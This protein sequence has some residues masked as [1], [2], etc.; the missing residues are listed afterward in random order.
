M[1][2]AAEPIA[3]GVWLI[4]GGVPRRM[5]VYAIRD[6]NGVLLFDAGIAQM[7][8]QILDATRTLGGITRVVLGHS[9]PDHRGAAPGLGAPVF[10]HP[11]E[12]GDAQGDGGRHYM[13]PNKLAP[14]ARWAYRYLLPYWDGGPV[15]VA[16]TIDEGEEVAGFEVVHLPGHAPGQIALW[17]VRDRL[18]LVS[19]CF[20]TLDVRTGLKSAPRA[21]HTAFT[22][23]VEVARESIRKIARLEP[24]AAWPGHADPVVGDVR[25]QLERAAAR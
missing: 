4:R 21:A 13:D 9:H 17:R 25:S 7:T 3:D 6:R 1:A 19:D 15:Q 16:G 10:C 11:L 24:A 20:Y 14:P 12:V 2:A 23:D 18:A 5:N 8:E 22:Q